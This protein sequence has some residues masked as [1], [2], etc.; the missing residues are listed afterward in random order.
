MI[1]NRWA[2]ALMIV[3]VS[4]LIVSCE[5]KVEETGPPKIK[6]SGAGSTFAAPLYKQWIEEYQKAHKDVAINYDVV[7]SGEGIK[8]FLNQDVDFGASDAA[9]SDEQM[10]KVARGAKLIPATAGAIVLLYNLKGFAGPLKL[11]REVYVGIFSGNIKMWNDPRITQAN[12][13]LSLPATAIILV[14]RLDSSGTTFAFTN[15][16]GAISPTWRDR[17][18]GV[19]TYVQWPRN[20]MTARGNEGVAGRIKITDGAIGYVEYGYAQR[21]GLPMAWL[22]NQAG[23]FIQPSPSSGLDTLVNTQADMPPNLRMFFPD[24]PG[25][26]SYPLVTYSWIL[27]YGNYPDG[28]KGAVVKDFIKWGITDGQRYAESLGY[29]P[30]PDFIRGL[31]TKAIGEIK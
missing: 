3:L 17:G 9:I 16:L 4:G 18:P 26:S 29:C 20:S 15:H 5:R 10:D 31:S 27:L 23:N 30:L 6:I 2:A 1:A 12:P 28:K 22:E 21:A 19:G 25:K 14:T 8:R 11:P 13:G 24:P 7:G